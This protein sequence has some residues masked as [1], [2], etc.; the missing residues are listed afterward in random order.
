MGIQSRIRA[1]IGSKI[2]G[3]TNV[4]MLSQYGKR[5]IAKESRSKEGPSKGVTGK[6]KSS[7]KKRKRIASPVKAQSQAT[8]SSISKKVV[9]PEGAARDEAIME[10]LGKKLG[11]GSDPKK[12]Q[13]L[14]SKIF[15][16]LGLDFDEDEEGDMDEP[17]PKHKAGSVNDIVNKI[18]G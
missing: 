14:E 5:D 18:L 7:T 3:N 17:N 12:R 1:K 9:D 11:L 6:G 4:E 10:K 16:D 15:A 13:Q 2:A 8:T